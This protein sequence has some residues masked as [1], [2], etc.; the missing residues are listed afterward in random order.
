MRVFHALVVF[1]LFFCFPK[2]KVSKRKGDF[3][4]TAPPAKKSCSTL[5]T[6]F[7]YQRHALKLLP[8]LGTIELLYAWGLFASIAGSCVVS[9]ATI[10]AQSWAEL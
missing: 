4:A 5:L 3:F 1:L 7:A 10:K 9:P 2:R 8:L 6:Q